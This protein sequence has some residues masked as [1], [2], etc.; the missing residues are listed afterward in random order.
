[1]PVDLWEY[2]GGKTQIDFLDADVPSGITATLDHNNISTIRA[3]MQNPPSGQSPGAF[4]AEGNPNGLVTTASFVDGN[5]NATGNPTNALTVYKLIQAGVKSVY[6]RNPT[7]RHT[8]TVSR[9]WTIPA[10]QTNVG[11]IIS[12][13]TMML[14][15]GNGESVP[16][17][18]LFNLPSLT[19]ANFQ[20]IALAYGWLKHDPT[21]QQIAFRKWQIIQ[22]WEF[23]LWATALYGSPL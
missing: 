3:A 15:T 22:E 17:G 13:S 21:I 4:H 1:M 10:S 18:L 12:T 16:S 14:T 9:Y 7:L 8:Q 5:G 11:R 23:G 2:I 19:P 20:T 6:A